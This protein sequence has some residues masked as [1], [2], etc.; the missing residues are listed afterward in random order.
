MLV[1]TKFTSISIDPL[2][3]QLSPKIISQLHQ[4]WGPSGWN[5][6]WEV[7]RLESIPPQTPILKTEYNNV[8]YSG[9]EIFGSINYIYCDIDYIDLLGT[10][11]PGYDFDP[12]P[13]LS[14][15]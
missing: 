15:S 3:L 12:W 5:E 10:F 13:N 8:I 14:Q 2:S 11:L 6:N 9:N 7:P 1:E 4:I